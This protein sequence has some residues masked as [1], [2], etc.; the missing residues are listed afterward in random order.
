MGEAILKGGCVPA[1]RTINGKSLIEN[2]NLL[3]S[4]VGAAA[5]NHTHN[6]L[7]KFLG[8]P[9]VTVLNN[10]NYAYPYDASVSNAE[11]PSIG[12]PAK[13]WHIKYFRHVDN[14]GF[15]AQIAIGLDAGNLMYFRTSNGTSWYSWQEIYHN[16]NA[17]SIFYGKAVGSGSYIGNG[18]NSVSI[19]FPYAIKWFKVI[20]YTYLGN[21]STIGYAEHTH[22]YGT[23]DNS[24]NTIFLEDM[25]LDKSY[26]INSRFGG[27]SSL[28]GASPEI[29]AVKSNNGKTLT[30]TVSKANN[31]SAIYWFN[32]APAYNSYT[33]ATEYYKYTY[34]YF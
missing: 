20:F 24:G 22:Y 8:R 3:A 29:N 30:W 25:I 15:G 19:T 32:G 2:I 6:D 31:N 1:S 18:A 10:P 12:L 28:N 9:G 21:E 5:L 33:G 17:D 7:V 27:R 26:K 13:W 4:D 16:G 11:A 14:N 23:Y 34:L